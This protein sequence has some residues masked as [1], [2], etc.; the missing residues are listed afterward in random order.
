MPLRNLLGRRR[1]HPLRDVA[2]APKGSARLSGAVF[3]NARTGVPRNLYWSISIPFAPIAYLGAEWDS[4]LLFE[5][6]T[7]GR[8]AGAF[9]AGSASPGVATCA[10]RMDRHTPTSRWSLKATKSAAGRPQVVY[11]AVVDFP[12]FDRDPCADL[13]IAGAAPLETFGVSVSR[14]GV[15]PKPSDADEARALIAGYFPAIAAYDYAPAEDE[16]GWPIA[17]PD[18][19]LFV[20]PSA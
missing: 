13:R 2:F 5:W 4:A 1:R 18:R 15:F 19:F 9:A 11:D 17:N 14:D 3:E 10:W 20:P 16:G 12:G 6:L 8:T 7:F